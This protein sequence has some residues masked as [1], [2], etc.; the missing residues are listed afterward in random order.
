MYVS[1]VENKLPGYTPIDVSN[2]DSTLDQDP[3]TG[4]VSADNKIPMEC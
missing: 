4:I 1:V 3:K 2:Y